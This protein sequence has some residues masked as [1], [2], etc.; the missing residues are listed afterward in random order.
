MHKF[1][2]LGTDVYLKKHGE[3]IEQV[4]DFGDSKE[5]VDYMVKKFNEALR[6]HNQIVL[7][8]IDDNGP[9]VWMVLSDKKMLDVMVPAMESG[10]IE[11]N[12]F[13][14][15]DEFFWQLVKENQQK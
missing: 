11:K 8:I 10:G 15:T 9:P 3:I 13:I 1:F 2:N 5:E 14:L 6:S 12:Y 7:K 4:F